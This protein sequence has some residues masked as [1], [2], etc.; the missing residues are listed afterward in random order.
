MKNN[1]ALCPVR[2]GADREKS[3]GY[4]G[5]KNKMRIAKYYLHKFEEPCITGENGSGT[6]F[7]CAVHRQVLTAAGGRAILDWNHP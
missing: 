6:V 1:C 7:F 2:C 4:C 5:E 3:A